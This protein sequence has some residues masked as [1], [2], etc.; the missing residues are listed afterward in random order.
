VTYSYTI[1]T[2]PDFVIDGNLVAV[3]KENKQDSI[4]K[5]LSDKKPYTHMVK[6]KVKF[7]YNKLW[8]R[9]YGGPWGAFLEDREFCG[10]CGEAPH[11]FT[12]SLP[13]LSNNLVWVWWGTIADK[14]ADAPAMNH[15]SLTNAT[16]IDCNPTDPTNCGGNTGDT[17]PIMVK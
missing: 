12:L 4:A 2:P 7:G 1:C 13:G 14:P 17:G 3:A 6:N 10:F 9:T 5:I 15:P 16:T 8:C 11:Q